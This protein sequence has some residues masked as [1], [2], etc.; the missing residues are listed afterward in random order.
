MLQNHLS[1]RS[2]YNIKG[3]YPKKEDNSLLKSVGIE[4]N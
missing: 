1:K 4:N 2:I 3:F